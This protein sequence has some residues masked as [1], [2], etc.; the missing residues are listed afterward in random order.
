MINALDAGHGCDVSV[1]AAVLG[2]ASGAEERADGSPHGVSEARFRALVADHFDFVWRSLRGLGVSHGGADDA[3]QQVFLV[4]LG[5]LG[6]LE[7]GRE[8][9][10]LFGTAVGV[11]ANARRAESRRR[12]VLDEEALAQKADTTRGP[13]EL[14]SERQARAVL[15]GILRAMPMDLTSVFVLFELEGLTMAEIRGGAYLAPGTV[16]S[17][18]RRAREAF[19]EAA[20]RFQAGQGSLATRRKGGVR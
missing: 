13:E 4:L 15:D 8:R 14:L 3:A 19:Q 9:S 1:G 7:P 20:R 16:A 2:S 12:E 17:R 10:F 18:L 6:T 11:A 5:K